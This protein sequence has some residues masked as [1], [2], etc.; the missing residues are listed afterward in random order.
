[1]IDESQ[2]RRVWEGVEEGAETERKKREWVKETAS[3]R[4]IGGNG[5]M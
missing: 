4:I 3:V 5:R 1:M 2:A